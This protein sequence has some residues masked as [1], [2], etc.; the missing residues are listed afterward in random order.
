M[1][2]LQHRRFRQTVR[3]SVLGMRIAKNAETD[4]WRGGGFCPPQFRRQV[5]VVTVRDNRSSYFA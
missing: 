2:K 4:C 5:G 3:E 1:L